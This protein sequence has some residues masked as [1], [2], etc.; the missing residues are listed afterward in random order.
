MS[1]SRRKI[2]KQAVQ[3]GATATGMGALAAVGQRLL[4]NASEHETQARDR[5]IAYP[6]RRGVPIRTRSTSEGQSQPRGV[7]ERLIRPPGALEQDD[8]FLA[9]CIRCYRCQDACEPGAVQ[10]FTERD[11]RHYHTPYVDPAVKACEPCMKCTQVCPTNALTPLTMEQKREV[12]MATVELHEDLCLSYK[13]KRIRDEQA[14]MMELGRSP[15]ESE[16]PLERRGPCGECFMFCPVRQRAIKL[17]PGAFLAP[18]VFPD[19]CI[20]CGM[21]EEICRVITRGDPAIRVVPIREWS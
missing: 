10:F 20:G 3:L 12:R 16:A 19:E 9:A 11:G 21:C 2:L 15:T 17:E 18:V 4:N 7:V 14:M 6:A 1:V 5:G 13:A 8:D